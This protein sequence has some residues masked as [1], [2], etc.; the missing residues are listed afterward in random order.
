MLN[1][2]RLNKRITFMK[3]QQTDNAMHQKKPEP[4][5]FK[6]VW[7]TVKELRGAEYWDAKRV[8][9]DTV[10]KFTCRYIRGITLDM[11][12]QYHEYLYDITDVNN[13]DERNEY[14]EILAV[15]HKT[16]KAS[17]LYALG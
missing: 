17:D 12:I 8:R 1:I 10:Y 16:T 13:V 15:V 11:Q 7:A 3:M 2:G 4:K 6:A 9:P 14:L 5:P